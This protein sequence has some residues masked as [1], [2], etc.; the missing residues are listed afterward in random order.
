MRQA[1]TSCDGSLSIFPLIPLPQSRVTTFRE[2]G[3]PF[4]LHGVCPARSINRYDLPFP[5]ATA[6]TDRPNSPLLNPPPLDAPNAFHVHHPPL[7]LPLLHPLS[8]LPG[9]L[10]RLLIP[11][12]PPPLI[13]LLR[14]RER[15]LVL[16]IRPQRQCGSRRFPSRPRQHKQA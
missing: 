13:L 15:F 9:L 1:P 5:T 12:L 11:L 14:H 6:S 2:D 7:G 8:P 10:P 4:V 16:R 3:L